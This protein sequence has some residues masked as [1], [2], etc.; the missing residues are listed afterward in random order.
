MTDV[1]TPPAADLIGANPK[2]LPRRGADRTSQT[3]QLVLLGV[4]LVVIWQL[5]AM[6][7]NIPSILF[8]TPL[9]TLEELGAS[10]LS[11]VSG[12]FVG[13]ALWLTTVEVVVGFVLAAAL[14]FAFG[15]IVAESRFGQRVVMPYL[16][17]FNVLPKVAFAPVL[18]AWLGFGIES[19]VVMAIL[20]AVFPMIINTAAGLASVDRNALM[21][22]ESIGSTRWKTLRRLKVPSA[23]PFIFAGLKSAAIFC[24]VGAV[25]GEYLGGGGG[26]GELIRLSAQQLRMERVFA[27][28]AYLSVLGLVVYGLIGLWERKVVFWQKNK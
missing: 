3:V 11:I 21:L 15:V 2:R 17:A 18:V 8:P 7:G 9:E 27:L 24:V 1:R 23:L 4:G 25:V 6:F 20:L 16:V 12:G 13:Q 5:V 22:F 19:K 10:A 14:G 26:L 28:I